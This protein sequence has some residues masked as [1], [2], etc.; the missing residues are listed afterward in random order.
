MCADTMSYEDQYLQALLAQPAV[1]TI[2]LGDG[3]AVA[4]E[5]VYLPRTLLHE[6]VQKQTE[7]EPGTKPFAPEREITVKLPVDLWPK[8]KTDRV[9]LVEGPAGMG[10]STLTKQLVRESRV[11]HLIPI[12]IPFRPFVASGLSILDYLDQHYVPWLGL[13]GLRV[14]YRADE[15]GPDRSLGQWCYE[16]WQ[17]GFGVLILDGLDEVFRHDER[18]TA[19][20]GLPITGTEATRPATILTSRPLSQSLPIPMAK[21]EVQGLT[22]SDQ[23]QFIERYRASLRLTDEQVTH[24]TSA[25]KK[26]EQGRLRELLTRP[27]HLIQILTTYAKTNTLL[28][29]ET[30]VLDE[31]LKSRLTITERSEPPVE[32]DHSEKKRLVLASLALQLLAC[33]QGQRHKRAQLLALIQQVLREHT[34]HGTPLFPLAQATALLNDLTR[35]SAILTEVE[36]EVYEF[37]AV[38]WLQHLTGTALAEEKITAP[39][40]LT[41]K[42]VLD[43]LDK[44]AWDPEWEPVLKSWVG[45]T[46]SPLLLLEGFAAKERDDLARHRLGTTGRCLVE[47]TQRVRDESEWQALDRRV[48]IEASE[49]WRDAVREQAE[50]FAA[51]SLGTFWMRSAAALGA[52]LADQDDAVGKAITEAF[53][54]WGEAMPVEVQTALVQCFADENVSVRKNALGDLPTFRNTIPPWVQEALVKALAD[55]VAAVRLVVVG[56]FLTPDRYPITSGGMGR[57]G[58]IEVITR[59]KE[60]WEI[61]QVNTLLRQPVYAVLV[62]RLSDTD[63][64]VRK[65]AAEA[66][67]CWGGWMPV[68]KQAALLERILYGESMGVAWPIRD[69]GRVGEGMSASI[70]GLLIARVSHESPVVRKRAVR[71]LGELGRVMPIAGRMAL[72]A[73]LGDEDVGV[74]EAAVEALGELGQAMPISVVTAL[75]AQL[76][77]KSRS[78]CEEA[79]RALWKSG[80]GMLAK[81][82]DALLK[83]F[84]D[85][86][87]SVRLGVVKAFGELGKAM[88]ASVVTALVARL[89]DEDMMVRQ[90]AVDALGG[91]G[92]A[93]S[94]SVVEG[95]VARLA[96]REASVRG[97]TV[98]AL[99][100]LGNPLPALVRAALFERLADRHPDVRTEVIKVLGGIHEVMPISVQ[101][102]LIARLAKADAAPI[103]EGGA[104]EGGGFYEKVTYPGAGV[105]LAVVDVFG[106]LGISMSDSSR[107]TLV[108]RL[109]DV[110]P[111]VQLAAVRALGCLGVAMPDWIQEALLLRLVDQ[112]HNTVKFSEVA[113]AIVTELRLLGDSMSASVVEVLVAQLSHD[114]FGVRCRAA[115]IVGGLGSRIPTSAQAALVTWLTD[116]DAGVRREAVDALGGLGEATPAFVVEA[117]VARLTDEASG[118]RQAAVEALGK[119]GKA[120]P[121]S[122]LAALVMRLADED[123][124]VQWM[125]VAALGKLGR[126]LPNSAL[127]I[128]FTRLWEEHQENRQEA[129]KL[130]IGLQRNGHRFFT[131]DNKPMDWLASDLSATEP[132]ADGCYWDVPKSSP[133]SIAC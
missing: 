31:L 94:A 120:M 89:S 18:V 14:P 91:L 107:S 3:A 16:Q 8:L 81:I 69:L 62:A 96:D 126:A 122:V 61:S 27:G 100:Q 72:I 30:A 65:A 15:T 108:T 7:H 73:R 93:M 131:V 102:A 28:D 2:T 92:K 70:L 127:E 63:D 67:E 59:Q 114:N 99:G 116:E 68:T 105:R 115:A 46:T 64:A 35:N 21:V 112:D 49:E 60:A 37:E 106:K 87:S 55:D 121:D 22:P 26:Q 44:K 12:W 103:R 88:P 41:R 39:L 133:F 58:R 76:E 25:T 80:R 123:Q 4:V 56:R 24:F 117:L 77:D 109:R 130:L 83:R 6:V 124:S 74:R 128:V 47:V 48:A 85:T 20:H 33:R 38:I 50:E 9:V 101:K 78:V 66:L 118:V 45:T 10:K 19:L 119:L 110:C 23:S 86:D 51:Q 32:G 90:V 13:A 125:A 98:E 42:K 40:R 57:F 17:S 104:M 97:R 43:F 34:T 129:I 71:V 111:N 75:V 29:T 113:D 5:Q 52:R 54:K 11:Q 84:A 132:L 95:L 36:P 1:S 82:Q 79:V 53:R